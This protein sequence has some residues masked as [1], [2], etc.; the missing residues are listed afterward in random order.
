MENPDGIIDFDLFMSCVFGVTR[1]CLANEITYLKA[2]FKACDLNDDKSIE[3]D[4]LK[5]FFK[6]IE[7]VSEKA[8][9]KLLKESFELYADNFRRNSRKKE[10]ELAQIQKSEAIAA[11]MG[12]KNSKSQ[13]SNRGKN[14]LEPPEDYE[15][16]EDQKKK[17]LNI[18]QFVLFCSEGRL[19]T[20]EKVHQFLGINAGENVLYHFLEK[21]EKIAN[22]YP[23]IHNKITGIKSKS[24]FWKNKWI[25]LLDVM[26]NNFATIENDQVTEEDAYKCLLQFILLEYEIANVE[27]IDEIG[28]NNL[29]NFGE[30]Y[31]G[32]TRA[33]GHDAQTSLM[34]EFGELNPS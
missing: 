8:S 1:M 5:I 7:K 21:K 22:N 14:R 9:L 27:M 18:D 28:E 13:S 2:I 3:F 16:Y 19:F 23:D 31:L 6:R 32:N 25:S 11:G 12:N 33:D 26:K 20:K 10:L 4:E 24:N 17:A 30:K 15:D 34:Q 29:E